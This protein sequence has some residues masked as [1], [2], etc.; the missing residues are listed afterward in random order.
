MRIVVSFLFFQA[1]KKQDV[2]C[3]A[4]GKAD[5]LRVGRVVQLFDSLADTGTGFG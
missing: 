5:G 2:L 4:F 3:G 1:G